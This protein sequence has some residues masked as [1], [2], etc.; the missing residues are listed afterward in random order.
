MS[1]NPLSDTFRTESVSV[2]GTSLPDPTGFS[3][4]AATGWVE[5]RPG[6]RISP[7]TALDSFSV[8]AIGRCSQC[9]NPPT[10]GTSGNFVAVLFKIGSGTGTLTVANMLAGEFK[11]NGMQKPHEFEMGCRYN[12]G[13]S[14]DLDPISYS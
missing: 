7:A 1:Y 2:C 10:P 13:D 6:T 11:A 5:S 3:V 4:D 14:E 9:F 8:S 12:A